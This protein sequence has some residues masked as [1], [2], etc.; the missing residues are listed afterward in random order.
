[1]ELKA[2]VSCAEFCPFKAILMLFKRFL[3][4]K[5]SKKGLLT[6][7][8]FKSVDIGK[9]HIPKVCHVII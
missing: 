9:V 8:L 4:A 5:L 3:F 2:K 6:K 7:Q 1:M